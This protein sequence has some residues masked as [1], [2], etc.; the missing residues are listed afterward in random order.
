MDSLKKY[1]TLAFTTLMSVV[2]YVPALIYSY[3]FS[4]FFTKY[5]PSHAEQPTD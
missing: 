3:V 4:E 2:G 1:L 5:L